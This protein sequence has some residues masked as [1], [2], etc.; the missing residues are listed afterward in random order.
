MGSEDDTYDIYCVSMKHTECTNIMDIE[1]VLLYKQIVITDV[2]INHISWINNQTLIASC[3]KGN[4]LYLSGINKINNSQTVNQ[5]L[6]I[7]IYSSCSKSIKRIYD[8]QRNSLNDI[9]KRL[10]DLILEYVMWCILHTEM[11]VDFPD[12]ISCIATCSK[13]NDGAGV[14]VVGGFSK[15]LQCFLPLQ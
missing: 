3:D 12:H 8:K 15:L 10:A 4:R 9:A 6:Y 11:K 14:V 2:N 13:A 5:L 1:W 7:A